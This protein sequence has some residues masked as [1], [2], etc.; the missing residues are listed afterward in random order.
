MPEEPLYPGKDWQDRLIGWYNQDHRD[1]P[2]RRTRDPYRIWVSEIMLQQTRVEAVIGYYRRFMEDF[3]DVESLAEAPLDRVLK[4]W[5]GLGYYSRARNL[6]KA[7]R[8]IVDMGG[9]HETYE[10]I[11]SLSGIGDYTAGAVWSIAYNRPA[12]AVDGNVLRVISRLY[13]YG[14][15][16]LEPTAR[17]QITGWVTEH[18]PSGTSYEEGPCAYT[19]ALME[20]GAMVCVPKNPRCEKCPLKGDCRA[21]AEGVVKTLPIRKKQKAQKMIS[22]YIALI[23]RKQPGSGRRETLMHRRDEKGLLGGLW[24]YPGV[25]ASSPE[26]MRQAF[27]KEWGLEIRPVGFL[28]ETEHV[29]THRHWK[30]QVYEALPEKEPPD[31]D[32]WCWADVDRQAEMMIPTAFRKIQEYLAEP[33]Q[34]RLV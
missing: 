8:Q 3:P 22:R 32:R 18:I 15:D 5:E 1:L 31:S 30:M 2:W 25:D 4:D 7:A 20:L 10:E 9:F 6:H 28:F 21:L 16:I 23:E 19:Q 11:R 33:E 12:A 26:E 13:A 27:S 29:F 24:E 34:L 17:R 14:E